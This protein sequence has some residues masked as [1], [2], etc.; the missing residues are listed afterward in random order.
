MLGKP[1]IRIPIRRVAFEDI[2][3][4]V[5]GTSEKLQSSLMSRVGLRTA[6]FLREDAPVPIPPGMLTNLYDRQIQVWGK[7]RGDRYPG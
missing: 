4:A 1:G 2:G 3:E 7:E 5:V 6:P